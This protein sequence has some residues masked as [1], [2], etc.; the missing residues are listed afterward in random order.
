MDLP[1]AM[2]ALAGSAL[3]PAFGTAVDIACEEI[4]AGAA[5]IRRICLGQRRHRTPRPGFRILPRLAG[6]LA[7][8][9]QHIGGGGA[10]KDEVAL[11]RRRRAAD[12]L[13]QRTRALAA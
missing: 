9:G 12:L 13:A 8:L 2:A 3:Q 5:V 6:I 7:A 4:P 1:A 10:G 11:G